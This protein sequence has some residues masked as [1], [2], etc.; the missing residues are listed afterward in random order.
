MDGKLCCHLQGVINHGRRF[1]I[2]R[3]FQNVKPTSAN[4]SIY[5][6]L[7]ELEKE[8]IEKKCLPDTIYH[9]IDGGPENA[10]KEYLVMS[11]LLVHKRLCQKVFFLNILIHFILIFFN[12]GCVDTINCGP[13]SRRYRRDVWNHLD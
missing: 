5:T 12:S 4:L 11:E 3:T 6:W 8:Y 10:N 2:Y 13:H 9:Q 7:I 1:V